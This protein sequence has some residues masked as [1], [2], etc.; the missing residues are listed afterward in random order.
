MKHLCG[1]F[2][3]QMLRW[4]VIQPVLNNFNLLVVEVLHCAGL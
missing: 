4:A 1:R 3:S 2:D